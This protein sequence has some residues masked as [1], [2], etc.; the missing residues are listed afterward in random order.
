[1]NISI[2][3]KILEQQQLK[4]ALSKI[5]SYFKV[6]LLNIINIF[7]VNIRILEVLNIKL[8]HSMDGS[9]VWGSLAPY[10]D[11]LSLFNWNI[12]KKNIAS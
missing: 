11:V 12:Y 3:Q 10:G 1:M 6:I 2:L 4:N 5:K 7:E 8:S 9:N